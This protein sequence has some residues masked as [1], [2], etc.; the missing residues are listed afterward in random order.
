VNESRLS[1]RVFIGGVTSDLP[2]LRVVESIVT[3][4]D[5]TAILAFDYNIPRDDTYRACMSLLLDCPKAVFEVSESG[6]QVYEIPKVFEFGIDPL[7]IAR[8]GMDLRGKSMLETLCK[9]HGNEIHT[10]SSYE[11]MYGLIAGYLT[12]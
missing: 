5:R 3:R 6:G 7:L 11:D 4:L 1:D 10:Y 9:Q 8:P 12:K 2:T